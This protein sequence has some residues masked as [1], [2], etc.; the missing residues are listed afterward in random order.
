M[1]LDDGFNRFDVIRSVIVNSL[2]LFAIASTL[3]LHRRGFF[4]TA[5][6]WIGSA[7]MAMFYQSIAEDSITTS[8]MVV[9][10]VVGFGF[11]V[12]VERF[13]AVGATD[14]IIALIEFNLFI[15]LYF[16]IKKAPN[17][18]RFEA[19]RGLERIRTAVGAFAELS[20]ATR[21]RDHFR[22]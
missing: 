5:V 9:V 20:L 15:L 19:I 6:L 8:S 2:V 4:T 1:L 3:I 12:F 10:M 16:N 14:T 7:I 17:Q 22:T 21:P 13:F 18:L 11:S